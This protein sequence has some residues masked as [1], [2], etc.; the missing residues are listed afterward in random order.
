VTR[1]GSILQKHDNAK[2]GVGENEP[3]LG[4]KTGACV[5]NRVAEIGQAEK[6]NVVKI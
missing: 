5:T 4:R 3:G 1:R 6:I 2:A